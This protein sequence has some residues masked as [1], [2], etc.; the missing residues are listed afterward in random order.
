VAL[1]GVKVGHG[2]ALQVLS[3]GH[4]H[5]AGKAGEAATGEPWSWA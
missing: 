5:G 2:K 1:E 3:G 4:A